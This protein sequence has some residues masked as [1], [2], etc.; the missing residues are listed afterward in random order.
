MAIN[1]QF[2]GPGRG[3]RVRRSLPAVTTAIT[4]ACVVLA[5]AQWLLPQVGMELMFHPA[6]ADYQPYRYITSAFLHGGFWH[7]AFNMY[8]LWILGTVLEPVLGKARFLA[9]YLISAI[10]GNMTITLVASLTNDWNVAA[11][12]ASGAIFGLFGVLLV[13]ARTSKSNLN[14]LLVLLGI[15]L[16]LSFVVPTISWES[17]IGGLLAGIVLAW[18]WMR[19]ARLG[20]S[21]RVHQFLDFLAALAVL[22]LVIGVRFLLGN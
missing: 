6:L 11:V 21:R 8:A 18:L 5:L 19:I 22:L 15:N 3:R 16:V 20:K 2:A 10:A 4:V 14:Q 17:H 7:I 1:N 12:G 13:A 9:L